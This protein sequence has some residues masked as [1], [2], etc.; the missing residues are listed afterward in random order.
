MCMNIFH[1]IG[2]KL[3]YLIEFICSFLQLL[4]NLLVFSLPVLLVI[5][6]KRLSVLGA[7]TLVVVWVILNIVATEASSFIVIGL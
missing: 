3:D 5:I 4:S 2:A 1:D 6:S 7:Q